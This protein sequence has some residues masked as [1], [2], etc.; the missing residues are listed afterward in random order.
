M[1]FRPNLNDRIRIDKIDYTFGEHPAVPGMIYLQEGRAAIVYKL[2]TTSGRPAALKVLRPIY[3]TPDMV[4]L[5]DQLAQFATIPGLEVCKRYVVE[6]KKD[7]RLVK[8]HPDLI[9]ALL[10][11]WVGVLS[12]MDILLDLAEL[13]RGQT[14][15]LAHSFLKT[16]N[17]MSEKSVSH[18]DLSAANLLLDESYLNGGLYSVALVDVEQLYSPYLPQPNMLPAGSDG[19]AHR[20][21]HH[22]LWRETADRF[23]GAI[24]L[25]EI[26]GW[27]DERVRE[28]AWGESYF[29][30]IEMPQEGKETPINER[31][32][33]MYTALRELWG[34]EVA[35]LFEQAWESEQLHQC[36]SFEAWRDAL[37]MPVAIEAVSPAK[38]VIEPSETVDVARPESEAVATEPYSR[39]A[40]PTI[41]FEQGEDSAETIT[42]QTELTTGIIP[43]EQTE[44]ERNVI[45]EAA[46]LDSVD[47]GNDRYDARGTEDEP[48]EI[49]DSPVMGWQP[50]VSD[51]TPTAYVEYEPMPLWEDDDEEE[52]IDDSTIAEPVSEVVPEAMP[53]VAAPS[54][55]T[56]TKAPQ[57]TVE[58]PTP[59]PSGFNRDAEITRFAMIFGIV[60]ALIFGVMITSG[61]ELAAI[62]YG[63]GLGAEVMEAI[64]AGTLAFLV[65][66]IQMWIFRESVA[67]KRHQRFPIIGLTSGLIAGA[68]GGTLLC[69]WFFCE[70]Y[71]DGGLAIG[72]IIGA[73]QGL[74]SSW[75]HNQFIRAQASPGKWIQWNTISGAII[76]SIAWMIAWNFGGG[77]IGLTA[78]AGFIV[79][80][81]SGLSLTRFLRRSPEVEF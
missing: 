39:G 10:M 44:F 55:T 81:G 11:P 9:Y 33:I 35:R 43:T 78:V 67:D 64:T 46:L 47:D 13:S 14:L 7:K 30:P 71:P 34:N 36:P 45:A 59:M 60:G 5:T 29:D 17:G 16:L 57:P 49:I 42:F 51:T 26:L 68:L 73:T 4:P 76:W 75:M 40:L 21:A 48:A 52:V 31:Y 1:A 70:R 61:S 58:V 25:A 72:A 19:Y 77:D 56:T 69:S 62:Q 50:L 79:L 74:L 20:T 3:R 53:T 24:L 37:P 65:G 80:F 22:G 12:W 23:A 38:A 28:A 41:E 15:N 6:A 2:E 32:T 66:C 63:M 8:Q 27:S 18:N 54:S